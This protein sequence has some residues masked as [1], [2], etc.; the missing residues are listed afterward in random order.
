MSS[1]YRM[2]EWKSPTGKWHCIDTS[3]FAAG[4]ANW[5]IP[6]RILGISPADFVEYLLSFNANVTWIEESGLLLWDFDKQSDMRKFKNT[7]NS[8]ARKKNFLI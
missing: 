6:C 7:I 5:W 2:D 3:N 4:S 1:I 8:I